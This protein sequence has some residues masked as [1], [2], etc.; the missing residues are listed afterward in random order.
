MKFVERLFLIAGAVLFV[1]LLH[2]IGLGPIADNLARIGWGFLVLFAF[3]G[4][5]LILD[6]LGWR[7]TLPRDARTDAFDAM[8]GMRLAGDAINYLTPT[9]AMGGEFVR[10]RLLSRTHP[11]AAAVGSVALLVL[12]QFFS[13]VL[14]VLAGA[15]FVYLALGHRSLR[16]GGALASLAV[17]LLLLLSGLL[18]LGKR[19]DGLRRLRDFV[20]RFAMGPL[21]AGEGGRRPV[22]G[23][24]SGI[25]PPGAD[26]WQQID[27]N[28]FGSY[29]KR[30]GDMALS[31]L[32]FLLAWSLGIGECAVI[33]FLLGVPAAWTTIVAIEALSVLVETALFF[34]PGKIGTQEGG[35]YFIF[36]SLGLNPATGFS[37]GLTRRVRELA[38]ALIGL[39][40][41]AV[42][43][44]GGGEG[45]A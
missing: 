26:P 11:P 21:P 14:F 38:W 32:C 41:L 9:A 15:P 39:V 23:P 2:R 18:Y 27:D 1:W 40:V 25:G 45:R 42:M 31:I 20:H 6:T 8:F 28:V 43:Q 13:Q 30:R 5:V 17:L 36:L 19:G 33:L 35:K 10:Y 22:E 37:F 3:Q 44:R 12:N 29:R 16:W 24:S 34:V 4:A 7:F